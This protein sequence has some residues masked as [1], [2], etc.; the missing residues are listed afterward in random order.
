MYVEKI[1]NEKV[2]HCEVSD[3]SLEAQ[4]QLID[5][6]FN[7]MDSKEVLNFV[8]SM[9]AEVEYIPEHFLEYAEQLIYEESSISKK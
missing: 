4:V 7:I 8:E 9:D 2:V 3:L 6:L 5:E 1:G